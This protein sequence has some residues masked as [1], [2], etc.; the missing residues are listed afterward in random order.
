MEMI[1]V[2]VFRPR[3]LTRFQP[4]ADIVIPFIF[5]PAGSVSV[6]NPAAQSTFNHCDNTAS[7]T[8]LVL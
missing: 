4:W 3:L 1:P 2:G 8:D 6:F 5:C 7:R